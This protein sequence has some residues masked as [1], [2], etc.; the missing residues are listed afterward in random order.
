M[1]FKWNV[2][3]LSSLALRL[4]SLYMSTSWMDCI[5][6]DYPAY[7]VHSQY[8]QDDSTASAHHVSLCVRHQLG[9]QLQLWNSL[10][11]LGREQDL[12]REHWLIGSRTAW[13]D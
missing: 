5:H 13:I 3:L 11:V 2:E 6:P 10:D 1:G 9:W 8:R 12:L 4:S 7:A